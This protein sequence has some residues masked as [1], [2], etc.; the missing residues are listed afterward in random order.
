LL[1]TADER[2][3]R[4]HNRKWLSYEGSDGSTD[5]VVFSSVKAKK[6]PLKSEMTRLYHHH[7][8]RQEAYRPPGKDFNHVAV[9]PAG[10]FL[11]L[12]SDPQGF[13]SE[14]ED[15]CKELPELWKE[16]NADVVS[17]EGRT[18]SDK[19]WPLITQNFSIGGRPF[20]TVYEMQASTFGYTM[21]SRKVAVPEPMLLRDIAASL[22]LFQGTHRDSTNSSFLST[23][24]V[25][26]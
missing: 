14:L 16:L 17:P 3:L 4:N 13:A 10:I 8:Y 25:Q 1:L 24:L 12:L 18:E 9:F 11:D 21:A 19:A 2:A 5:L 20:T 15:R 22:D 23:V 6:E 26:T 7:P